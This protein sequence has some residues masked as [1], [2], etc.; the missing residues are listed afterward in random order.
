[1]NGKATFMRSIGWQ[2]WKRQLTCHATIQRRRFA[3]SRAWGGGLLQ[4]D[5][6]HSLSNERLSPFHVHRRWNSW[7]KQDEM[8]QQRKQQS[9][10]RSPISNLQRVLEADN[11]ALR[12]AN[13]VRGHLAKVLH[14]RR[15][16]YSLPED[17]AAFELIEK[18]VIRKILLKDENIPP[19]LAVKI[20]N[21]CAQYYLVSE[22]GAFPPED[23]IRRAH[24]LF[25]FLF[26]DKER[27]LKE[28]SD[29]SMSDIICDT[30]SAVVF[31]MR[32]NDR[33]IVQKREKM[34][35]AILNWAA[36]ESPPLELT[37][38]TM[39]RIL[40]H[41]AH[42]HDTEK[43]RKSLE[44]MIQSWKQGNDRLAPNLQS[45]NILLHHCAIHG[46][47]E[48]SVKV[49]H[50]MVNLYSEDSTNRM[51]RPNHN[52]VLHVLASH[53][54]EQKSSKKA[55]ETAEQFLKWALACHEE[56]TMDLSQLSLGSALTRTMEAWTNSHSPEAGP[57]TDVLMQKIKN[58][59][60]AGGKLREQA[61]VPLQ[62]ASNGKAW[63]VALG[64]RHT[65]NSHA[66]DRFTAILK[67]VEEHGTEEQWIESDFYRFFWAVLVR[68]DKKR[69]RR[70]SNE[71]LDLMYETLDC[72]KRLKLDVT[73]V[74]D[75][76]PILK[77]QRPE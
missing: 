68:L 18:T 20:I 3:L 11:N 58:Q 57:R 50:E 30:F 76:Y 1:M 14:G 73:R 39:N 66:C 28:G 22:K 13:Y 74:F 62:F 48:L 32:S 10:H 33:E 63:V 47:H 15:N 64:E 54:K 71:A 21:L 42:S 9:F 77:Q 67:D 40:N 24:A 70:S 2:S 16:G 61:P 8:H 17:D 6:V 26:N 7:V 49:I 35:E 55:G 45:F 12:Q 56:G 44:F 31:A 41:Y 23:N 25:W 65:S 72:M 34:V 36:S 5:L 75:K 52:S 59:Y 51:Q 46:E 29:E 37:T 53:T 27:L 19:E 60:L 4:S 43:C 38:H 69:V